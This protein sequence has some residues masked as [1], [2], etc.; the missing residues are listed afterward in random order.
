LAPVADGSLGD[1]TWVTRN[2]SRAPLQ[3]EQTNGSLR[4]R[5]R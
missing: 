4:P 2:D 1:K 3:S 5:Q